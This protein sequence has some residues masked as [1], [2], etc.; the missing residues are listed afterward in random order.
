MGGRCS[1]GSVELTWVRIGF[2]AADLAK[3]L[4]EVK[5]KA[6][7]SIGIRRRRQYYV[8]CPSQIV[9]PFIL[10]SG[11]QDIRIASECRTCIKVLW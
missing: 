10:L 4:D 3:H 8:L 2:V 11:V 6:N 7:Y 1:C 5:L 9:P